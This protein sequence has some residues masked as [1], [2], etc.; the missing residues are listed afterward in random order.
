MNENNSGASHNLPIAF[1]TEFYRV[2]SAW[3][4]QGIFGVPYELGRSLLWDV[5]L[6]S[7]RNPQRRRELLG[8][9]LLKMFDELGPVYGKAGQVLLSRLS[10]KA[11]EIAESLDLVRLYGRWIPL[12]FAEIEKILD[13]EIPAWRNDLRVDPIALGV[14][15]MA[16]VHSCVD[17]EGREWVIKILKPKACQR[18][19]ESID[20]LEAMVRSL[21]P[22][23]LTAA[24]KSLLRDVKQLC[25]GLRLEASLTNERQ[26]IAKVAEKL[27]SRRQTILA[28]PQVN[29]L[30]CTDQVL[31]IERFRGLLLSDV[32]SKKA[33]L[34]A[35]ARKKLAKNL[36]HEL[37]IQIFELG[38]FHGDPHGGN[39][40]LLPNG[41]VGLFDWGLAGE[42]QESDRKH[43]AAILRAVLVMDVDRLVEALYDLGGGFGQKKISRK[44][45]KE[46]VERLAL[47][48]RS[49]QEGQAKASFCDQMEACLQCAGK[50]GMQLPEG[51]ILM[52][53]SLVTIE[54]LARG[55][56]PEVPL[57]R[58]ASP[59]LLFAA[60]PRFSD[61]MAMTMNLPKL[62]RRY[63]K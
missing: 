52:A 31:V 13:R 3:L 43:I 47:S 33:D 42:L 14:A 4:R 53:K 1:A 63:F 56:D 2:G 35:A 28:L 26:V 60:R 59:V 40:M 44:R 16:Q 34:P 19:A 23:A 38:L 37:L 54:G 10:G 7:A 58:I 29:E 17:Q 6:D 15:S 51:L 8:H 39:L 11:M 45:I 30:Y 27:R 22:L 41:S 48:L 12:P 61:L 9:A 62:T 18:L 25:H 49:R 5:R 36:L 21:E 20:L 50:L 46:E 57:G 55:I 24:G 32:V